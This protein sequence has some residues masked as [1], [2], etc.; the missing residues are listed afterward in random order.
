[1]NSRWMLVK[2]GGQPFNKPTNFIKPAEIADTATR[3][4][5][6]AALRSAVNEPTSIPSRVGRMVKLA[7]AD[8]TVKNAI[9]DHAQWAWIP[10]GDTCPFCL[11]LASQGWVNASKN[12]LKGNHCEHIHAHCDC[13]FAIAFKPSDTKK[14]PF[15]DPDKYYKRYM[16]ANGDINAMRRDIYPDIAKARN[17]RR[18]ILYAIKKQRSVAENMPFVYNGEN[19][20]IPAGAE[21]TN[22]TTIAG[23]GTKVAIHDVTRLV[24]TY[25]GK[26]EDWKKRVGKVE[27]DRFLIDIHWYE[28]DDGILIEE[29]IKEVIEK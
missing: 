14:Y 2:N 27:S 21:I 28:K 19:L 22:V 8:T 29:K 25:G 10:N 23:K 17:A 1:M 13:T 24:A 16:D 15:Y 4:E 3:E 5:V 11:M 7:G 12:V 6:E 9:R 26:A 18:K 20:Y